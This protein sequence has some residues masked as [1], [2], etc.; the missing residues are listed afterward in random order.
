MFQRL[1][2]FSAADPGFDF[3]R[4]CSVAPGGEF[5]VDSSCKYRG[6][7][8]I[9][10]GAGTLST[11]GIDHTAYIADALAQDDAI[12]SICSWHKNQNAAGRR[13]RKRGGLGPL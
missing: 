1:N 12:W 13:E 11:Q 10:S 6:I 5:G 9:L 7:F 3:N 4:D 8:M 2:L